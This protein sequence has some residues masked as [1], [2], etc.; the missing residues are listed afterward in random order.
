MKKLIL[1]LLIV[2]S[3]SL[4][5]QTQLGIDIDGESFSDE[6][7]WAV[8]MSSDGTIVAI[9]AINNG[10]NG[11]YAGHVRVYEY[12]NN[13]WT[14]LGSDIDG[15]AVGDQS[16]W[17]VSLSSDGVILAVG[18][19][20]NDGNGSNSGHVRVYEYSNNSW[21][22]LGSDIDGESFSD[23]SGWAVSLSSDGT[24]VAVGAVGNDGNGSNSGHVR[25]YELDSNSIWTQLGSDINGEAAGD[26]FGHSVSLSADGTIVA[27]G[28]TLNDGSYLNSGHV[29]VYELDSNL[30]WVQIGSDIDGEASN[31]FSG[32]SVSLS[33]DGTIVA[34]GAINNDGNGSNSGHVRV[35]ELDSNSIWT[36]LGSDINGEAAGDYSGHS[37][38]LSADGTIVAIG[39]THNDGNGIYAGHVRVYELDSNSIWTQLNSDIN[40]EAAVDYS[41]ISV[42]LSSDGTVLAIGAINNDGNGN[43]SGHL[44]VYELC[45]PNII[46]QPVSDTFSTVP[47]DAY[48]S[49]I[50]SN[51]AA[52]YLWQQ[53]DNNVWLNLSDTG[54]YSGTMTD[55]LVLTGITSS[56]NGFEYRCIINGCE[57]DTS[58][59]AIL[60]VID[61]IGLNN[62]KL[63]SVTLSPNPNSGLFSIQVGQEHI[64]SYYQILDNLGRLI[65]KGIIRDLSQDFDLSDKPKGVYRLQ[66]SNEKAF[67]TLNVLIQ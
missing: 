26:Y 53:N 14:Q 29:R 3:G 28:A 46:Q 9:G 32:R 44:R 35:Y 66:V 8:S 63:S 65:D 62:D 49:I 61:N 60:T 38:S 43:N 56:L 12:S 50:Y 34:I 23:E 33:D 30:N 40:G 42:S 22:Q 67:K 51:S 25:V 5:S 39:A 58:D 16:G 45:I 11:S 7:G 52:G 59:I 18:A 55:S 1:L 36:Q 4:F 21:T 6:S 37:V 2:I 41:G 13:S 17:A 64:G 47:G 19:V 31:D 10:G 20:G 24:I 15:E 54:V 48:F 27:I 57:I